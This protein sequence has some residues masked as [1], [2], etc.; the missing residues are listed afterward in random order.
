[1]NAGDCFRGAFRLRQ[2]PHYWVVLCAADATGMVPIVNFTT[3]QA[4][5]PKVHIVT[6]KFFPT[7]DHDSEVNWGLAIIQEAAKI[8][9]A[10][11]GGVFTRHKGMTAPQLAQLIAEGD[12]KKII[13][14]EIRKRLF[15][16]DM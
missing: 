6:P 3:P 15:P 2:T 8:A 5:F 12:A 13:P 10:I 1:M 9:A 4:I 11:K 7:L 14:K 16:A